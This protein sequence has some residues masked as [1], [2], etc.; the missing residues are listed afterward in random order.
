[1]DLRQSREYGEYLRQKGW[2]VES[3]M[4]IRN[5]P[6]TPF[7]VLKYQR[8]EKEVDWQTL[9]RLQKKYRV[10]YTV[11]EPKS[12]VIKRE[13]YRLSKSPYLPMSTVIVDL[14]K[15]KKELKRL[16]SKDARQWLRKT[17]GLRVVVIKDEKKLVEFRDEWKRAKRGYVLSQRD[18]LRLINSF[19][20]K[21]WVL[22]VMED[23]R[24]VGGMITLVA[25]KTAY[26]YFAWT[27]K[28]GR[29]VGAQYRLVWEGMMKAKE[30]DLSTWDFEGIYDDRWP[31]KGWRGFSLFKKKFGGEI[32]K[33]PGSWNKWW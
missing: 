28:R 8:W 11:L 31:L 12:E 9:K 19:G 13:G 23:Y 30:K 32:I 25:G 17:E 18:M 16:V 10:I 22:G 5:I 29:Q 7:S 21:C 33:F 1:M 3:G 26:Y 14:R 6:L 27:S 2:V 4:L 20:D 15:E 24:L